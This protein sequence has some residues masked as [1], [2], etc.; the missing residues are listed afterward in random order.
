MNALELH[1]ADHKAVKGLF[2][3][4]RNSGDA[5]YKTRASI[6]E[7]AFRELMVHSQIEEEIFYPAVARATGKEGKELVKEANEEHHVVDVLMGELQ[8]MKSDDENYVAKFTVLMENVE[9]HI[10]EEEGEMFPEFEESI[11]EEELGAIGEKLLKRKEAL[12]KAV[13]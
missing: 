12:A 6:A 13:V 10:E 3:D 2:K 9:H 11:S 5:A 1:K 4:F 7:K 8:N